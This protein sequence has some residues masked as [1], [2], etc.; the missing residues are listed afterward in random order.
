MDKTDNIR[1][2]SFGFGFIGPP[3]ETNAA[4]LIESVFR[5]FS[6]R[7]H[8]CELKKQINTKSDNSKAISKN[9]RFQ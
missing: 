9:E 2:R 8:I 4:I 6:A 3:A 7:K 5:G 1:K